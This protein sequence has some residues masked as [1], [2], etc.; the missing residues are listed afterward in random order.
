MGRRD[1]V[2]VHAEE[3]AVNPVQRRLADVDA[4][5]RLI[6][7]EASVPLDAGLRDLVSWWRS[8]AVAPAGAAA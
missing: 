4:A 5:R 7:F 8:E 3:R 6:G 1:L 2:P